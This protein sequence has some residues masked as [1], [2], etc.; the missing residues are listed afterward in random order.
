M[1]E[2]FAFLHAH[3]RT[4]VWTFTRV[5]IFTMYVD[6]W[7]FKCSTL[8]H[9]RFLQ[10][11]VVG[12]V[13]YVT[14]VRMRGQ[15]CNKCAYAYLMDIIHVLRF[16]SACVLWAISLYCHQRSVNGY[17]QASCISA[18]VHKRVRS[19]MCFVSCTYIATKWVCIMHVRVQL[20]RR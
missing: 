15:I 11:T 16:S 5:W 6:V 13:R 14:S 20:D 10:N 18:Y 8:Q 3:V 2:G 7:S 12:V 4:R 9:T 1:F 17:I 19:W